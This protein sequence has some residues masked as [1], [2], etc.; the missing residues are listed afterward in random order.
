TILAGRDEA[1]FAAL[2]VISGIPI[3]DG[4][5][6]DLG[7]GSLEPVDVE[8]GGIRDGVTLPLGPLRLIDMSAASVSKARG[9]IDAHLEQTEL[10]DRLRGRFFYAVGGTWRN[11]ARLHM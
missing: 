1:Q 4:V 5:V 2:G 11:L 9:I 3:A 10:M 7:G 6:G 8:D